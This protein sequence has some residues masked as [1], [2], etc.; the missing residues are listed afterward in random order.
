[1]F[2]RT[3]G[4]IFVGLLGAISKLDRLLAKTACPK[5]CRFR[6]RVERLRYMTYVQLYLA[7]QRHRG[8]GILNIPRHGSLPC[9]SSYHHPRCFRWQHWQETS[10]ITGCNAIGRTKLFTIIRT[11]EERKEGLTTDRPYSKKYLP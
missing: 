4:T 5:S 9:C 11:R 6:R 2:R 7:T 3:G 8:S 1:M 10:S